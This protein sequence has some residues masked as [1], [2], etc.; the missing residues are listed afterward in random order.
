M[1]GLKYLSNNFSILFISDWC[2]W[3]IFFQSGYN[4]PGFGKTS[5][6]KNISWT[7]WVLN[8]ETLD[9]FL[10]FLLKQVIPMLP[11]NM[12]AGWVCMLNSLDPHSYC[13]INNY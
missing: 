1:T 10:I 6:L 4:F 2:V 8:Y 11:C 3:M 9:S 13:L 12:R 5:Y 7:F